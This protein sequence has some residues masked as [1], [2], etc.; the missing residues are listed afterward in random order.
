MPEHCKSKPS[1]DS[2]RPHRKASVSIIGI[3]GGASVFL[4]GISF[5]T[6]YGMRRAVAKRIL[7]EKNFAT[8]F[9]EGKFSSLHHEFNP[10]YME[11]STG[12]V[13]W[14]KKNK[15]AIEIEGKVSK[16]L[17]QEAIPYSKLWSASS[18]KQTIA[19]IFFGVVAVEGLRIA[20]KSV[21]LPPDNHDDHAKELRD[22]VILSGLTPSPNQ[23]SNAVAERLQPTPSFKSL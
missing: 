17:K 2:P 14:F 3:V 16:A 5:L 22:I 13:D 21:H 6:P 7:E 1:Q 8:S 15:A 4:T 11:A 20:A 10:T 12:I 18:L 19:K 23:L 9:F